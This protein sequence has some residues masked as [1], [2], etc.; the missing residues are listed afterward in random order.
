MVVSDFVLSDVFHPVRACKHWLAPQNSGQM[1]IKAIILMAA[2]RR[3]STTVH[4]YMYNK[5]CCF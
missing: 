4:L 1:T 2:I 3:G 5:F